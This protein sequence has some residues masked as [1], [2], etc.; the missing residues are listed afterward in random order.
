MKLLGTVGKLQVSRKS[1]LVF[2][3]FKSQGKSIIGNSEAEYMIEF[4]STFSKIEKGE[5]E[6]LCKAKYGESKSIKAKDL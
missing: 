5:P 3:V 2:G 6:W 4:S 1:Y